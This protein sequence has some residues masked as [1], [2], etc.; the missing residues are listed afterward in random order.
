MQN[1]DNTWKTLW[2]AG[3]KTEARLWVNNVLYEAN[4]IGLLRTNIAA[5]GSSGNIT[6]G[7]APSRTLSA[8]IR[9]KGE[10]IP[11]MAEVRPEMRLVLGEQTTGWIPKGVFYIDQK[12]P[13]F[14]RNTMEISAYDAL[15]RGE[16]DYGG[17]ALSFPARDYDLLRELAG[18]LGMDIDPRTVQRVTEGWWVPD[19]TEMTVREALG[20]LAGF[21]LGVFI[22]SD[23]GKLLLISL[24]DAP[25]SRVLGDEQSQAISVGGVL[26]G[27]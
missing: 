24:T 22:T 15:M 9:Y 10:D 5:F 6:V 2:E 12:T 13:D 23:E 19:V 3:A 11:D 27:V 18:K 21:Y 4:E 7:K 17:T 20:V 16:A 1:V 14:W 8:K 26:I 25:T